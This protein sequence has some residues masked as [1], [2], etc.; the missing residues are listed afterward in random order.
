MIHLKI[1]DPINGVSYDNDI[2]SI[3]VI[4][5]EGHI[6]L[7]ANVMPIVANLVSGK[8]YITFKDNTKRDG[9]ITGGLLYCDRVK[10][11][12]ILAEYFEWSKEDNLVELKNAN[13]R[14]AKEVANMDKNDPR[15]AELSSQLFLDEKRYAAYNN[16]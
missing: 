6:G 5:T 12:I 9:I 11:I 15:F 16:K 10:G 13:D 3:E 1:I 4:T 14:L 2:N 8:C 7:Q